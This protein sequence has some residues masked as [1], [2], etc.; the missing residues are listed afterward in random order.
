MSD[1]DESHVERVA[2]ARN[3]RPPSTGAWPAKRELAAALRDLL[4][5]L[6]RT[7]APGVRTAH[8]SGVFTAVGGERFEAFDQARRERLG[9]GPG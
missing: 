9:K 8:A 5:R 3:A 2:R 7:A 6:P 4:A 1:R